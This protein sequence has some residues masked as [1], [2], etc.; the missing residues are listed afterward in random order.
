MFHHDPAHSDEQLEEMEAVVR[1]LTGRDD[2][3]LASEGMA[4]DL[5]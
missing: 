2:V 5:G 1:G 3:E 4:I